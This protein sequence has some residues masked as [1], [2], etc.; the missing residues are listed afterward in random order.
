MTSTSS[1]WHPHL[2]IPFSFSIAWSISEPGTTQPSHWPFFFLC[3]CPYVSFRLNTFTAILFMD[4]FSGQ[5]QQM[6]E[7]NVFFFKW[8]HFQIC[9]WDELVWLWLLLLCCT[10]FLM[11]LLL[12]YHLFVMFKQSP[13]CLNYLHSGPY[14]SQLSRPSAFHCYGCL[15]PQF[16]FRFSPKSFFSPSLPF[17]FL[18]APFL[19]CNR[20]EHRQT[21]NICIPYMLSLQ[22]AGMICFTK[23]LKAWGGVAKCVYPERTTCLT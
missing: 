18:V 13:E 17:F 1:H 12:H 14:A 20:Q 5:I 4:S 21:R 2:P 6:V 3:L 9:L 23:I 7:F 16:P 11:V 10:N 22:A 8:I 15:Y 19:M